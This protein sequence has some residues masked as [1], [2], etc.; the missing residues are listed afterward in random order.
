MSGDMAANGMS[1]VR[2]FLSVIVISVRSVCERADPQLLRRLTTLP[3][4][5]MGVPMK[6]VTCRLCAGRA[7]R[8]KQ[9]ETESND[10][11]CHLQ[12][13]ARTILVLLICK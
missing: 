11:E 1:D 10:N 8:Q 12:V 5:H 9:Q 13:S 3:R 7:T 2:E 4:K 6:T